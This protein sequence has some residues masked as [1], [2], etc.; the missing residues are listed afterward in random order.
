MEIRPYRATDADVVWRIL[1]PVPRGGGTYA[2][3]SDWNRD[4]ARAFC[5]MSS[6]Q[7]IIAADQG[8][9][10]ATCEPHASTKVGL[11]PT[12]N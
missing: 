10:S 11:T 7:V 4:K 2:L 12:A 1:E 8:S 3:P 5:C 9:I 6:N